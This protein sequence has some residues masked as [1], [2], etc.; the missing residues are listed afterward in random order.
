[1]KWYLKV[2][3]QYADFSGRA[4][5]KEFW[6]FALFNWICILIWAFVWG[7]V[8]GL[9]VD[10]NSPG[11]IAAAISF[12]YYVYLIA[13]MLPS[14]AVVV[15]R[16]HDL[17]KSGWWLFIAF[18]PL[19]GGVW[20]FVLMCLE[21]QTEGNRY[22][23]NPKTSAATFAQPARLRSAGIAL[24][25]SAVFV[26]LS[27]I[28]FRYWLFLE[29]QPFNPYAIVDLL[30]A[31][32][33]LVGAVWLHGQKV[34]KAS[35]LLF[36]V[37]VLYLILNSRGITKEIGDEYVSWQY[38]AN[39]ASSAVMWL[40]VALLFAAALFSPKNIKLAAILAIVFS[41]INFLWYGYTGATS[42]AP[43]SGL[44]QVQR[45][46]DR[47]TFLLPVAFIV[48]ANTLSRKKEQLIEDA[49]IYASAEKQ[50]FTASHNSEAGA[51]KPLSKGV[52][53]ATLVGCILFVLGGLFTFGLT[54][55]LGSL[56]LVFFF[57][58]LAAVNI[59]KLATDYNNDTTQKKEE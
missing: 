44:Q 26:L 27:Q 17:G 20:L 54:Q 32:A 51:K 43:A 18:I 4:R 57:G 42:Q 55:Q 23:A 9:T 3:R 16:L 47:F 7:L 46:A 48:I 50:A 13:V 53:I 41:A 30:L 28:F 34:N 2:L 1:M 56:W 35:I 11:K 36:A 45:I 15:R 8:F 58:F 59:Y 6:M 31:I 21:G 49:D 14:L 12:A 39:R 5:R 19:V 38:L 25:V 10:M 33:L 22:G 40:F 37:S 29:N 52:R 24:A